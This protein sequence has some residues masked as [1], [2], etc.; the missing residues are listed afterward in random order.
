MFAVTNAKLKFMSGVDEAAELKAAVESDRISP[1]HAA[2]ES[3]NR[4]VDLKNRTRAG[5][6]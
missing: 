4:S 6:R 5:L 1:G 2:A 3:E